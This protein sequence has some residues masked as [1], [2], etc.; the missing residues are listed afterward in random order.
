MEEVNYLDQVRLVAIDHPAQTTAY[1]NERFLSEKPFPRQKVIL[2]TDA[3]PVSA[4]W[5]NRGHNVTA[6]LR[7]KD[8]H[9]LEDFT[10]L[11]YDGFAKMHSLTLDLGHWNP[12]HPLRLF[13]NGYVDYFS[14]SSM[15][16]AW[17]AGLKPIP[18]F[19]EA[20]LPNGQWKPVIQDMG[21]PAGLPR[22]IAVNLTGKL[23]PGT[24][25]IRITTNLQI[26]W[27]Q[28][29]V[30]N[31]PAQPGQIHQT[32]L[33]LAAATLAFRGYPQQIAMPAP[34][35][36]TYNYNRNSQTGPFMHAR[37]NYTRYGNVTPLLTSV[38]NR[39]VVFGTGEDIDLE[40]ATASLPP[41]PPGWTR[42]YFFYANGFVKDM[43][44]YEARPYTVGPMP[45]HGM[46]SYPPPTPPPPA[47]N[48]AMQKY[49]L[50]WNT[51]FEREGN[52]QPY[53]FHYM[54]RNLHPPAM[55]PAG[56]NP[57]AA[58]STALPSGAGR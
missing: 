35:L 28:I 20:L 17:Q 25:R 39:F 24:R 22:T 26:Y 48:K 8:G 9:Y 34:G 11:P 38:D 44:F 6:I 5:G 2:S 46:A 56:A 41:L 14:A 51:R 40:F 10:N 19:I 33:Q 58:R 16:A 43:D 30:D 52:T 55:P 23:P 37:G 42:D 3:H 50:K 21:F 49:E 36:I 31:G 1:P 27:D 4:A 15:Y 57:V 53:V 12:D 29:L 32:P 45:Y 7:A 54:L 13:L 18:P 47:V